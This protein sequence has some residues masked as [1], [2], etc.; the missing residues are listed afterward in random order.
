RDTL[1]KRSR[2]VL[3]RDG[4][5]LVQTLDELRKS[6]LEFGHLRL[7][8]P[9][10]THPLG[11]F[12]RSVVNGARFVRQ[13]VGRVVQIEKAPLNPQ[14]ARFYGRIHLEQ[15]LLNSHRRGK[16]DLKCVVVPLLDRIELVI[17]ASGAC[18]R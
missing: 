12:V 6:T 13:I 5:V 8:L 3:S 9:D 17:V 18:S 11:D 1:W 7:Q 14:I 4:I 10:L 16:Y 15:R 2:L